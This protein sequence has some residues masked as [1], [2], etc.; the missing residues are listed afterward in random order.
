M[1]GKEKANAFGK[2]PDL[3]S[4]RVVWN[5]DG[6]KQVSTRNLEKQKDLLESPDSLQRFA[7][8]LE[9]MPP[10]ELATGSDEASLKA[11]KGLINKHRGELREW[12]GRWELQRGPLPRQEEE[13]GLWQ[14]QFMPPHAAEEGAVST[15]LRQHTEEKHFLRVAIVFGLA[16][17]FHDLGED[18]TAA[19]L[20][21]LYSSSR[22]F[23]HVRATTPR[24]GRWR[25]HRLQR[26]RHWQSRR[27][28]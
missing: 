17:L 4:E 11:I 20:Y 24:P 26:W 6:L 10:W 12:K 15:I 2:N 21:T 1:L 8:L 14:E 23:A 18:Y 7:K 16:E 9:Q 28:G 13:P 25:Q 3:R 27:H 5:S 19:E 22:I